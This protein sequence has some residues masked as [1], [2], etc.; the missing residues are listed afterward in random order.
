MKAVVFTLGCKVNAC[1]SASL[2]TGL[3][4]LGYEVSDK[5]SFADLYILNTCAVTSEAEKK[6]RQAVARIRAI[7]PS[8]RIIVTGCAAQNSPQ[9]FIEKQGVS[10]ISRNR[11]R[12]IERD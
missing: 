2:M 1:E 6:S 10:A 9:S 3:K 7:N 11:G 5:L 12:R 8:A 4:E